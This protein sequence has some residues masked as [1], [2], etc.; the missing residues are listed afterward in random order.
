MGLV[1]CPGIVFLAL[2]FS[3]IIP[4]QGKRCQVAQLAHQDV[5]SNPRAYCPFDSHLAALQ[6]CTA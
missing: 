3:L 6:K 2:C 1:V 4:Q 5:L